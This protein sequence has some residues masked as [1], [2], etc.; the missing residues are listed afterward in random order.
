[1]REQSSSSWQCGRNTAVSALKYLKTITFLVVFTT[2]LFTT[3]Y[4]QKKIYNTN[5]VNP[6]PPVLDG[7]FSDPAW[8]T[9]EWESN[10]T[11]TKPVE[12]GSPSQITSFKIVY[13]DNALYVAIRAED[14]EPE[15]ISRRLSKRDEENTDRIGLILDSY[16]DKRTGFFFAVS[17]SGVKI[18]GIISQ[19]GKIWDHSYDPVWFV[20]VDRD[21]TGWAAE[22][23]IPFSQ[24]RFAEKEEQVWGLSVYRALYRTDEWMDWPFV[25]LSASGSI[26]L[27][28]EL[29]GIN[30]IESNSR[31]ELMPYSVGKLTRFEKEPGN[32]F[33]AGSLNDLTG[34]LDGKIGITNNITMDFTLNPDFGQVEADPSEVNLTTYETFFEE[35]RP[36]FIE[37]K[38]IFEF[39]DM[40]GGSYSHDQ[41]F[42]S[43][44]VGRIPQLDADIGDNEYADIPNTT[45][46]LGAAKLTGKTSN[47]WSIGFVEVLTQEE[48]AE[49]DQNS[50]RRKTIVEPLTNYAVGR[51]QKD[52]GGGNTLLGGMFTA[53][54]R[55]LSDQNRNYLADRAYTGGFDFL[56]YWKDKTYYVNLKTV[57]S[58]VSGTA[59]YMDYLQTSSAHYFQRPDS[60]HLDFDQDRTRLS[61]HGGVFQWGKKG[62]GSLTFAVTTY[63]RS[64]GLELNDLGYMKEAD[65]IMQK[66]EAEYTFWNPVGVF[67][68][69]SFMM[70]TYAGWNFGGDKLRNGIHS[71]FK[72][73]F[74]NQW[75]IDFE[76]RHAASELATRDL[77]GGPMLKIPSQHH[78]TLKFETDE[79]R[80]FMMKFEEALVNRDDDFSRDNKLSLDLVWR[81]VSRIMVS[82]MPF[83]QTNK[84]NLQYVATADNGG[85]P[86]Y[87]MGRLDQETFGTTF[88]LNFSLA[89]DLTIQYYGQPFVSAGRYVNFKK[90]T[91]ARA[92][93]YYERFSDFTAS[94]LDYDDVSNLFSVDEN[95]DGIPDYSFEDPDFNFREFRSNLVLRWEYRPGSVAYL[96]WS[97]ERAGRVLNGDFSVRDD[98]DRLFRIHPH[99][100][101][102]LKLSYWFNV[103]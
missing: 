15:K 55:K 69:L 73:T 97:Q 29:H 58:N 53:T 95:T 8:N 81:P 85:D 94:Q 90:I 41:L 91:S 34:G 100:V 84:Q 71:T 26:H 50:V 96:V 4:A 17:S 82:A 23:R 13:D 24:I 51:L 65:V 64:P 44:R 103:Q 28:G 59:E 21:E 38:N 6:D 46:V 98:L 76:T 63:W 74:L 99:N 5:R 40:G 66:A 14:K 47:G 86:R 19:D 39:K 18:D 30:G 70:K 57:V 49:I 83:F 11:Q 7:K 37:G 75:K 52:W 60:D 2:Y 88:R 16:F 10:F 35:K 22:M 45:T 33:A 72:A 25:P 68:S 62:N 92:G 87:I 102:L 77:R 80:K 31:I 101:F 79:R 3:S 48:K 32:P 36:F 67:R 78:Y 54:N 42:Y 9:V 61:G 20:E 89:P 12:G 1:M 27:F 93:G 56:H 43:R